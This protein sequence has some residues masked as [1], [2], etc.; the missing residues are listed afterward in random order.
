ME[1]LG[2]QVALKENILFSITTYQ[3]RWVFLLLSMLFD[4]LSTLYFVFESDPSF[5][6]NYI[7]RFLIEQF[8]VEVGVFIGKFLQ[9]ISVMTFTALDRNL[10]AIFLLIVILLNIWATCLNLF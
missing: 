3:I 1:I 8:D 5:E 2:H 6:A 10:G 7:I 4:Y 9:L